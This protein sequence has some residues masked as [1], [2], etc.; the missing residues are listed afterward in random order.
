LKDLEL[1]TYPKVFNNAMLGRVFHVQNDFKKSK[2]T[3]FTA[4]RW[5]AKR[6]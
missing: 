6:H 2:E 5:T 4:E 3:A 1:A